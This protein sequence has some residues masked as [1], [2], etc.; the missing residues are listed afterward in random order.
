[1]KVLNNICNDDIPDGN[2]E[3]YL[4]IFHLRCAAFEKFQNFKISK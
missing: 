2:G 1:M 3:N 4:G